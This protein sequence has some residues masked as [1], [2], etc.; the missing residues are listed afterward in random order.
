MRRILEVACLCKRQF[1][2]WYCLENFPRA[3]DGAAQYRK[4]GHG[5]TCLEGAD[6]PLLRHKVIK[7]FPGNA[8]LTADLFYSEGNIIRRRRNRSAADRE[9]GLGRNVG[10]AEEDSD[11][12]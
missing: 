11:I 9:Y 7:S 12:F 1:K 3:E 10:D 8:V 6:V 5:P 2:V 4:L